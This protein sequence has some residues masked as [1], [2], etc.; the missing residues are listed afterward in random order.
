LNK[1]ENFSSKLSVNSEELQY[2]DNQVKIMSRIL[3]IG[4]SGFVGQNLVTLLLSVGHEVYLLN[5]GNNPVDGTTHIYADRQDQYEMQ[6]AAKKVCDFDAIIDTSALIGIHTEIAW[7]A[8]SDKAPHWVHLSS[9]SVYKEK[10]NSLPNESDPIGGAAVWGEYGAE[11]AKTDAF[12]LERSSDKSITILRPPYLYGP[13]DPE[14]RCN[15][16]WGR[17]LNNQRVAIPGDGKTLIQFLHVNDLSRAILAVLAH[18]H[19]PRAR[20]TVY[21][22]ASPKLYTLAEWVET[23]AASIGK[24]NPG[25]ITNNHQTRP[26]DYF[27][28]RNYP[29]ALEIGL[30][31]K[32]TGWRAQLDLPKGLEATLVTYNL[33]DLKANARTIGTED[34]ILSNF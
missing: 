30:I 16:I 12:L 13:N 14:D 5:R 2:L 4:G 17:C 21:N 22:V 7:S 32:H 34:Q 26:R 9:A 15:Y 10:D 11:K 31:E 18:P 24:D 1:R 23:V 20:A 27:C 33:E 6:N 25:V 28:F 19:I 3:V 8:L 29:C